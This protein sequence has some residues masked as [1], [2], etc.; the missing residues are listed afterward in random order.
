MHDLGKQ[1]SSLWR[2]QK[3]KNHHSDFPGGIV[4]K[5]PPANAG[6]MGSIPCPGRFRMPRS[7]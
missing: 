7:S 4:D 1:I 2:R 6:N 3:E 5:N